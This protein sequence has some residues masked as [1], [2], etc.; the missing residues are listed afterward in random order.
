MDLKQLSKID[1]S[2]LKKIDY[3]K[4]LNDLRKRPEIIVN[5]LAVLLAV[6]ISW[7]IF[8]K[9]KSQLQNAL[10]EIPKMEDKIAAINE[11]Q[12][13]RE[14]L[15]T[16]HADI[17]PRIT[18]E[19]FINLMTELASNRKIRILSL[20]PGGTESKNSYDYLSVNLDFTCQKYTDIW[21]FINDIESSRFPLKITN[22]S[23]AIASAQGTRRGRRQ[24]SANSQKDGTISVKLK[25]ASIHVKQ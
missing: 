22:L 3:L 23:G 9:G 24:A 20:S 2:E 25:V 13:I 14:K 17:A 19:Q 1:V 12:A 16:F 11:F 6:I 8:A 4:L 18:E 15:D 21:L 5:F 10:R 7:N